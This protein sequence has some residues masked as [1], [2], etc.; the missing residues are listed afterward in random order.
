MK[1]CQ[2][3]TRTISF[4]LVVVVFYLAGC[5]GKN[6]NPGPG[7]IPLRLDQTRRPA[8]SQ[9]PEIIQSPTGEFTLTPVYT[10]TRAFT[11][12]PQATATQQ[13]TSTPLPPPLFDRFVTAI[14]NGKAT[15]VVGVYVE[16]VLALRVIQQ[17][18]SQP[19]FVSGANN[20]VTYFAMVRRQTGNHGLLAHN[21]LAGKYYFNLEPGQVVVLIYGDGRTEDFI[22]GESEEFQ[23]LNPTSPNSNFINVATGEKLTS[24]SLFS[25][26]YSGSL[27]T[28][29]QT[30]IA[31]GNELS[32]GRLFVI[33]PQE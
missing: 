6:A 28:T 14:T 32:W 4:L 24:T 10:P 23:A 20:V 29:F 15:Q 26:V 33:A 1:L 22:V 5:Q 9:I 7:V 30:C 17:P 19:A 31:Q 25:K 16:G 18:S 3:F 13:P 11:L 21:F 12:T 2:G 27:H 8:V